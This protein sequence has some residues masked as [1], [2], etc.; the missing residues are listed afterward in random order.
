M[1]VWVMFSFLLTRIPWLILYEDDDMVCKFCGLNDKYLFIFTTMLEI[2]RNTENL[3]HILLMWFVL[4]S[5][6]PCVVK[7]VLT[8]AANIDYVKP[9]TKTKAST[10]S[11][12]CSY[13]LNMGLRISTVRKSKINQQIDPVDLSRDQLLDLLSAKVLRHY[14]ATFRGN[15]PPKYILY[16]RM[17]IDVV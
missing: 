15:S 7:E 9:L 10:R 4:F 5:L 11:N 14:T 13:S 2:K 6:S 17:K 1:C 8:S 12:L 16:K 3:R